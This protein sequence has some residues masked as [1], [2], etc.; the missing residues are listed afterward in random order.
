MPVLGDPNDD[1][2]VED[3][4]DDAFEHADAFD[5]LDGIAGANRGTAQAKRARSG[6]RLALNVDVVNAGPGIPANGFGFEG[7]GLV[8]KK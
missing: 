8:H 7:K 5:D 2:G 3:V 6:F 1:R 4:E